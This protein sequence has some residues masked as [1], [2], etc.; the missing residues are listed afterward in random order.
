MYIRLMKLRVAAMERP[1]PS[2][3]RFSALL[4]FTLLVL[5]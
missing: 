5:E 3:E 1:D 4:N 2:V